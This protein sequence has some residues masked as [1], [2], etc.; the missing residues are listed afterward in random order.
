MIDYAIRVENLSCHFGE[1]RAVDQLSLEIPKGIVFGF[2]GPNGSGKTTTIRLLL[3]LLEPRQGY[4]EVLGFNIRTKTDQLRERSGALLEHTGLYERL[5]AEE[6]LEFYG[7]I[8]RMPQSERQARIKELLTHF[9]LWERCRDRVGSW[10]RGMK[11]KLAVSRALLHC[12]EIIFLD[13]PTA[14]LDPV[15]AASLRDDIAKLVERDGVTVFL[16]THNPSEAEKLC[17]QVGVIRRGRLL[18]V[19]NPKQLRAGK[20]AS[21]LQVAGSGFTQSVIEQL[22]SHPMV[23]SVSQQN[24]HMELTLSQSANTSTLVSFLINICLQ[25]EEVH[26]N[27]ADLEDVFLKLMEEEPNVD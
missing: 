17:A 12:P 22:H 2:L 21:R 15:A 13:E 20:Y 19:G 16:N 10:S 4:A 7:R 26:K 5:S 14:G 18:S 25:V 1:I 9:D 24:S 3:G 11:Q 27:R 23:E 6:N 8:N